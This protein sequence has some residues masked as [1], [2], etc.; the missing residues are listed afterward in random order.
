MANADNPTLESIF[1]NAELIHSL[2]DHHETQSLIDKTMQYI[3]LIPNYQKLRL[4]PQL[5]LLILNIIKNEITKKE[6]DHGELLIQVF[7]PLFA[8]NENEINIIKQQLAFF[9]NNGKVK[10]IPLSKKVIK[11]CFRWVSRRIG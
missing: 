9:K 8:L 1:P 3:K 7:S 10:G 4:D 6:F 2:K 11:S 5:T